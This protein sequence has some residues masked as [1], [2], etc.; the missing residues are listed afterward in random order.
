MEDP[1]VDTGSLGRKELLAKLGGLKLHGSTS[2]LQ[3]RLRK[4]IV[5]NHPIK[6]YLNR[7]DRKVVEEIYKKISTRPNIKFHERIKKFIYDHFFERCAKAPMSSLKWFMD[8]GNFPDVAQVGK[9]YEHNLIFTPTGKSVNLKMTGDPIEE[10][11]AKESINLSDNEKEEH[12]TESIN[13][14]E[15]EEHSTKS[16]SMSENEEENNDREMD[17]MDD[18]MDSDKED[19]VEE[20]S[21]GMN[22]KDSEPSDESLSFSGTSSNNQEKLEGN[23]RSENTPSN[24][25][26]HQLDTFLGIKFERKFGTNSQ[27][28]CYRNSVLNAL[29]AIDAYRRKLYEDTCHCN[30]CQYFLYVLNNYGRLIIDGFQ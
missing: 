1:S 26:E 9:F 25:S 19:S 27:N 6:N 14:S 24:H 12:A 10:E 20:I 29:L 3:V 2:Q 17:W 15:N 4:N 28:S 18:F 8:T 7:L 30:L 11:D 21:S 16:M 22:Q 13:L 23:Q 5:K